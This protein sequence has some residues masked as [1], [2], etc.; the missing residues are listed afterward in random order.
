[1]RER[2]EPWRAPAPRRV[3]WAVAACVVARTGLLRRLG[4]FDP[5]AFLFYEDL[6]LCLRAR[7]AGVP[8]EL[9]PEARVVHRGG[10][11]TGPGLGARLYDMQ[12]RRRREV[13]SAYLGPGA[14]R[15]DDAGQALTFGARAL[16]GRRRGRNLAELRSLVRARRG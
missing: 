5:A 16:V 4:P 14:L 1:M 11:A 10:H 13:I 9:R 7:R 3:G 2:F 12:A 15:R 8:T 6:E